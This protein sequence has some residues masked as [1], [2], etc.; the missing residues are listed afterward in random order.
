MCLLRTQARISQHHSSH[1]VAADDARRLN[2]VPKTLE[3]KANAR[4][5]KGRNVQPIGTVDRELAKKSKNNVTAANRTNS[6][7]KR[8]ANQAK[9]RSNNV[10]NKKRNNSANNTKR[11]PLK[12]RTAV[13]R[14]MQ[15]STRKK[16]TRIN[17]NKKTR[18]GGGYNVQNKDDKAKPNKKHSGKKSNSSSSKKKKNDKAKNNK[19]EQE[20]ANAMYYPNFDLMACESGGMPPMLFSPTYLSTT[21]AECCAIHFNEV[22]AECV[23]K[24]MGG[25]AT[26]E[27]GYILAINQQTTTGNGGKSGKSGGSSTWMGGA[28]GKS[29]KGAKSSQPISDPWSGNSLMDSVGMGLGGGMMILQTE[30]PTYFPSYMPTSSAPTTVRYTRCDMKN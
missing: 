11:K 6:T 8:G 28:G 4:G 29:G 23:M 5:I 1:F 17:K 3:R 2:V 10:I 18:Y 19:K 24:S 13:K 25:V 14:G 27:G 7:K 9:K 15:N 12:K 20:T 16:V 30:E 26:S 22:L 21:A